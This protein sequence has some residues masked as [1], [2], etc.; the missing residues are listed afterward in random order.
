MTFQ[1]WHTAWNKKKTV[2]KE[3]T[4]VKTVVEKKQEEVKEPKV[5]NP[6]V[7]EEKPAKWI[8]GTVWGSIVTKPVKWIRFEAQVA[9]VPMFML[10]EHLQR[11][12]LNNGFGTNVWKRDKEWLERHG[13][14]MEM[15]E[16]LKRFL[17]WR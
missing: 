3:E 11:Y 9:P 17:S 14:D 15:I 7:V 10:P 1:K 16:E 8:M 12:L 2:K 5:T 6:K 4:A 13:A